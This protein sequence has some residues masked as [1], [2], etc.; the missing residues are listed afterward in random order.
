VAEF[1]HLQCAFRITPSVR[2]KET[3][4]NKIEFADQI[5]P[6]SGDRCYISQPLFEEL[7]GNFSLQFIVGIKSNLKKLM[8][9]F[10]KILSTS[11]SIIETIIDQLK[12]PSLGFHS[13]VYFRA[14]ASKLR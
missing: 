9:V 7:L 1:C 10:D 6:H 13:P 4:W 14:I 2:D 12:K 5:Q 8:P 11:W 3:L